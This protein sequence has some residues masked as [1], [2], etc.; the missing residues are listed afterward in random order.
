M[1]RD[2]SFSVKSQAEERLKKIQTPIFQRK[3][4]KKED[5]HFIFGL[6]KENM[7]DE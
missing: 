3:S 7:T 6:I 5:Y 1:E 4:L 2:H